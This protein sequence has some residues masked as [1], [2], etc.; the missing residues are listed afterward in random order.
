MPTLQFSGNRNHCRKNVRR[1]RRDELRESQNFLR[2][3]PRRTWKISWTTF[4]SRNAD[5]PN[6]SN[7]LSGQEF[8]CRARNFRNGIRKSAWKKCSSRHES[9]QIIS[10]R[11]DVRCYE[12][13]R[14]QFFAVRQMVTIP[15]AQGFIP[16]V[17][18]KKFQ[19]WRFD[20]AVAKNHVGVALMKDI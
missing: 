2:P 19:R 14:R 17:F 4:L 16:R 6:F 13:L 9:A 12:K 15:A 10:E 3:K 11:T 20:V 18:K 5:I 1:I 7:R 8:R